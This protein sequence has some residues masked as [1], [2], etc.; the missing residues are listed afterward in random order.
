MKNNDKI[1]AIYKIILIPE[2]RIIYIGATSM[3]LKEHLHCHVQ[4]RCTIGKFLKKSGYTRNDL[5]IEAIEY[6]KGKVQAFQREHDA[7][8]EYMKE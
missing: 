3:D 2:D 7:T 5:K 4:S 6:I 1:Y 8:L